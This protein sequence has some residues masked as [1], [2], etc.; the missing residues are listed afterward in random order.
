METTQEATKRRWRGIDPEQRAATRRRQL[1]DAGLELLGTVGAVEI[2]MRAVCREA[3]LTE[4]YFYES[5]TNLEDLMVAVLEEVVFGARETLLAALAEAPADRA[6]RVRRVVRAFGD[7]LTA[8]P[9]RGRVIF[10]ESLATPALAHRGDEL[11]AEFT[12]PIAATLASD[13]FGAPGADET[14]IALNSTAIFGALAFLYRPIFTGVATLERSRFDE[15]V[16][17]IIEN[18]SDARSGSQRLAEPE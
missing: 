1:L 13:G 3:A 12:T 9:R 17:R 14:D 2:S 8:D 7:Y 6:D 15:H 10:V 16:A 5:F 11:I 4:R 18:I